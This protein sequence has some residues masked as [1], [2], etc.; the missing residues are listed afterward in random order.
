ML[1]AILLV[2]MHERS[3][4]FRGAEWVLSWLCFAL[5]VNRSFT[6]GPFQLRNGP[7]NISKAVSE[8]VHV[9]T[10]AGCEPALFEATPAVAARIWNGAASR[11]PGAAFGYSDALLSAVQALRSRI[12]LA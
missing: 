10:S 2:E 11:Q 4:F 9:L 1:V 6:R 3:A 7:W 8:A 5:G 12:I